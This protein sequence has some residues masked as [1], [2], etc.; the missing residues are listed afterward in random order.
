MITDILI[1]IMYLCPT[2][3]VSNILE[4]FIYTYQWNI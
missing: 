2:Y 3:I 4:Y 1:V